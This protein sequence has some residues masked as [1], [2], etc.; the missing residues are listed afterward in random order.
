MSEVEVVELKRQAASRALDDLSDGMVVGLGSG[1]TAEQGVLELGRRVAAGL[2]IVG[3]PSSRKIAEL[4]ERVGVP[5]ASLDNQRHLD[6]TFDGADE[7]DLR[8]FHLIKGRGGSLLREKLVAVA[9]NIEVIVV[10]DSKLVDRLGE[11]MPVPVEVVQFGWRRTADALAR[12]GAEPVLR[13]MD[14]SPFVSDEGHF[15]L[16]CRFR[17]IDAPAALAAEIKALTG[18]VEHVLFVGLARRVIVA[19]TD[20][21]EVYEAP[22]GG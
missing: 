9:T 1:S 16:D 22:T 11:R 3:V 13:Q 5:L 18:V 12:L 21:V 17:P 4:A 10:D 7:V 19:G 6:L 8:T 20:G 2:K 15:I 14:G